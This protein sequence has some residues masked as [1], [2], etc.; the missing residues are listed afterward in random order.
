MP[1]YSMVHWGRIVKSVNLVNLSLLKKSVVM[2]KFDISIISQNKEI[3]S[4]IQ[5]FCNNYEV[6]RGNKT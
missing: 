4:S 2:W 6:Y 5:M 3:Y 1:D